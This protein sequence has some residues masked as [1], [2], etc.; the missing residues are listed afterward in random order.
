M[1]EFDLT[2]RNHGNMFIYVQKL[3]HGTIKVKLNSFVITEFDCMLLVEPT[4]I[5]TFIPH[6]R[7]ENPEKK[8]LTLF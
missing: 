2:L 3:S 6:R 5:I 7:T 8:K 4:N 1:T